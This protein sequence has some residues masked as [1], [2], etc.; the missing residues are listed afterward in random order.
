[1]KKHLLIAAAALTIGGV[2]NAQ[3]RYLD[4]TFAN[5]TVTSQIT[6]GQNF[7]FFP[8]QGSPITPGPPPYSP[9]VGDLK[10]N[11]YE[12]TGDV[13]TSRPLV[14]LVHTGN[15]LPKYINQ[16]ATGDYN[17]SAIVELANRF[18]KR[19]YVVATP[20]YR[21][22]WN[23]LAGTQT[24]RTQQLLNAVYRAIHDVQ[25]CVRYFKNTPAT[26]K[27]DPNKIVLMGLGSGGYVVNAYATLD[28]QAET[29]L[30]KFQDT[31]GN[32]VINPV[33]VGDVNGVG[34][35]VNQVNYAGVN[36]DVAMT[37]NLG[38]ALGDIS[39]LE[40]GDVPMLA[41]HCRD[42][43]FA[44]YDSG[45]VIVP[46]TQEPVVFVHG[47]RTMIKKAVSL[48]NNDDILNAT[49]SDA[50]SARAYSMNAKAQFEGLFEFRRP[51]TAG[52]FEEAS[53]WDW[54]D[55]TSVAAGA[56]AVGAN[57]ATIHASGLLT[58]PDMSANKG[59]RY[60]D[61]VMWYSAPRIMTVLG[62]PGLGVDN[63][64]INGSAVSVYPNPVSENFTVTVTNQNVQSVTIIDING[65]T[66]ATFNNL[67]TGNAVISRENIAAGIYLV[68]IRT[69][70][71][72][73]ARQVIFK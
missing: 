22:G 38:G 35:V 52:P 55:S 5:V 65:K 23:P 13:E 57:G 15:F 16:S 51:I 66:V 33:I 34:G 7:Y 39:W 46:T 47:S 71:G 14:V 30:P 1:M 36:K 17:D 19:G 25:T 59:R 42:D 61:T 41:F 69:A 50:V 2:A 72:E 53:P 6:F 48:G 21:L 11:L 43:Q 73:V 68:K 4:E 67:N 32:S 20:R 70:Q 54:W 44:P 56:M 18:A 64:T 40:A 9:T 37:I 60:I 24:E 8:F 12:P 28:A 63:N 27:V 62:L 26:H 31:S 58:N 29:A 3:L 49:F 10:M 45:T